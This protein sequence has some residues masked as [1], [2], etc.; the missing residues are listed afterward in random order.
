VSRLFAAIHRALPERGV[1]LVAEGMY[2]G[3]AEAD[4]QRARH[5][6][7]L[8]LMDGRL[9][10]VDSLGRLLAEAGFRD[11][12]VIDTTVPGFKVLRSSKRS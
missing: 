11:T 2:S 4:R 7:R 5:A 3:E 8:L 9:R 12:S 6:I 10:S 1:L